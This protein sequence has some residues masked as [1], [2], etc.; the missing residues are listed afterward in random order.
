MIRRTIIALTALLISSTAQSEF[1]TYQRWLTLP[2]SA[3]ALHIAGIF[4]AT[5][6]DGMLIDTLGDPLLRS[7]G[8]Q[9]LH[10][11]RCV[12]RSQMTDFQLAANVADF[13]KDKPKLQIG[14]VQAALVQYLAATC[15]EP[16]KAKGK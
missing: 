10:F 15:G 8:T 1:Y 4:D 6:S 7:V 3:R 9:W 11:D 12:N 14:S 16:P 2:L 5:V 13:A